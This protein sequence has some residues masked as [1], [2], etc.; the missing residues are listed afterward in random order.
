MLNSLA[1]NK[2]VTN[3]LVSVAAKLAASATTILS[4]PILLKILGVEKYGAW[5]TLT[6][7]LTWITIF[8]FGIG[9]GLKN[10]V[11]RDLAVNDDEDLRHYVVGCFQFTMLVSLV[12]V[13]ILFIAIHKIAILKLN[14]SISLYLYLPYLITFPLTISASVLQGARKVGL[15]TILGSVGSVYWLISLVIIYY[16]SIT[17]DTSYLAL[18]YAG[19]YVLQNM[20]NYYYA[21]KITNCKLTDMFNFK[22]V[23]KSLPVLSI[24]IRFLLLQITSIVL[25]SIGNYLVYTNLSAA[26]AALYD[27]T[28][29]LFLFGMSMFNIAIAVFWPEFTH[30]LKLNDRAR[31]KKLFNA[32]LIISLVFSVGSFAFAYAVPFIVA[33]WTKGALIVTVKQ[34]LPF[35]LL[36]SIQSLAYCGAVIL[37]VVEAVRGQIILAVVAAVLMVPLSK[38]FFVLGTG[39]G[40]IPLASA[41]LTCPSLFYCLY[42]GTKI[43]RGESHVA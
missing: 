33:I 14:E 39:I 32:L 16:F 28:N 38:W 31:S 41:I 25:F 9:Y 7:M 10:K 18:L 17:L 19:S 43:I 3:V 20:L 8:D 35:A 37:N 30:S 13:A 2:T 34:A 11:T 5:V 21:S 6:S 23:T 12:L 29:K 15:Q 36:V 42:S 22:F 40:S 27:S 4:V 24:G 1:A 26:D